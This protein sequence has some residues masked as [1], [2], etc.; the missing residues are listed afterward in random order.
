MKKFLISSFLLTG[1]LFAE[2]QLPDPVYPHRA[3]AVMSINSTNTE[4]GYGTSVW[5]GVE[6]NFYR[7]QGLNLKITSLAATG[8]RTR[9]NTSFHIRAFYKLPSYNGMAFYPILE[10]RHKLTSLYSADRG[11]DYGTEK[12]FVYS[13]LGVQKKV[14]KDVE[15]SAEFLCYHEM[16]NQ[17]INRRKGSSTFF[18]DRIHRTSGAQA[19]LCMLCP[20]TQ[21]LGFE[22]NPFY[23]RSFGHGFYERGVKS[24]VFY[25]F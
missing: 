13:G 11:K 12:S 21:R 10:L 1:A 14:L 19:S 22:I 4:D 23:S 8:G 17:M 15:L 25:A 20:L 3:G 9:P 2:E 24:S 18:G 7:Q 16:S 5:S 6:Y